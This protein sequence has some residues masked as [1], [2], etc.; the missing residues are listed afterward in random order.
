MLAADQTLPP[1]PD[2]S[3]TIT[4]VT[5]TLLRYGGRPSPPDEF[6]VLFRSVLRRVNFLNYFHCDGKLLDDA[7]ELIAAAEGVSTTDTD[8]RWHAWER[9]S[10][11]Q[12]QRVPMSGF[13]GSVTYHG[14][15][16]PFWPWLAIGEWIHVGKGAT[17]GLGRYEI[18]ME[19]EDHR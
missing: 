4:L 15:L 10:A 12:D 1:A 17:F 5:P 2:K 16:A 19:P 14:D 18:H 11:R 3:V 7:G 9:Y 13:T 6:H 8:L